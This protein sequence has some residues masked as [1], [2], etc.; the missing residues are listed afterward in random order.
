M[1][2]KFL[3]HAALVG[4]LLLAAVVLKERPTRRQVVGAAIGTVGLALVVI[5]HGVSAPVVPVL[6]MLGAATSWAIGRSAIGAK[7]RAM[8]SGSQ[9]RQTW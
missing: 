3:P 8:S 5:A 7:C 1:A 2:S 9:V 4:G 6:V